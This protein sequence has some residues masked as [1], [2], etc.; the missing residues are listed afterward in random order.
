MKVERMTEKR[1][2]LADIGRGIL[3]MIGWLAALYMTFFVLSVAAVVFLG[4]KLHYAP[5]Y[6]PAR[7]FFQLLGFLP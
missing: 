3:D 6:A 1:I 4:E 5:I 7:W 2:T